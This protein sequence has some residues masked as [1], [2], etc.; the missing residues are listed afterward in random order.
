MDDATK[1]IRIFG[2][3]QGRAT[4]AGRLQIRDANFIADLK[5]RLSGLAARDNRLRH[6]GWLIDF[7]PTQTDDLTERS[8]FHATLTSATLG[9][10]RLD[11][12]VGRDWVEIGDVAMESSV[13]TSA[14]NVE[15]ALE[16]AFRRAVVMVPQGRVDPARVQRVDA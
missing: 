14:T 10:R 4:Y 9:E 13:R 1:F 3:H 5:A 8:L 15:R 2:E 12:R 11:V 6:S 16:N 7:S